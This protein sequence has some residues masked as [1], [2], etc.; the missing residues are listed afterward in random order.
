MRK[1]NYIRDTKKFWRAHKASR[2]AID[3]DI[4]SRPPEEQRTVN[5][6]M[7]ANHAAMRNAKKVA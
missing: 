7:Q 4:V 2:D 6:K 1:I 5:S 3:K